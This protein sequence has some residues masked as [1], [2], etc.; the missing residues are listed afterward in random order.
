LVRYAPIDKI[1]LPLIFATDIAATDPTILMKKIA[2]HNGTK[3]KII[4]GQ[5]ADP[6]D[7]SA[8]RWFDQGC[9]STIIG[10]RTVVTAAHCIGDGQSAGI[11]LNNSTVPVTCNQDPDYASNTTADVALCL[12][13]S[14]LVAPGLKYESINIDQSYLQVGTPITL[15][16]FG[17]TEPGGPA[18]VLYVGTSTISQLPSGDDYRYCLEAR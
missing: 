9:T 17:C 3:P 16:G 4:G 7:W 8:T 14:D 1:A 2:K 15:L 6:A 5:P 18:G 10:V 12:A 13:S 11:E